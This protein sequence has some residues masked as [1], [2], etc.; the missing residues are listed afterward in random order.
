MDLE[1]YKMIYKLK[2]SKDNL[3]LLGKEFV[4]NNK[5][6]GVIVINNKK[7]NL[8]EFN[9]IINYNKEELKIY[10]ILKQKNFNKSCMFAEC[11]SLISIYIYENNKS[12]E[13]DNYKT[14]IEHE[15]SID[16][17]FDKEVENFS[18]DK[19]S[20]FNTYSQYSIISKEDEDISNISILFYFL[21]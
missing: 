21:I 7:Y 17:H 19:V 15:E 10:L 4:E 9:P 20:E 12:I 1:R 5:N 8:T 13:I 14:F 2:N 16:K 3:R 11:F 18:T 6:K